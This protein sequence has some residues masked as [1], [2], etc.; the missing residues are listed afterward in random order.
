MPVNKLTLLPSS[1]PGRVEGEEAWQ[2][3]YGTLVWVVQH[4]M[5]LVAPSALGNAET[6]ARMCKCFGKFTV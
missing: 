3:D 6:K 2:P 1:F 4:S 5:R